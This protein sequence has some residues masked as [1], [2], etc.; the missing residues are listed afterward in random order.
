MRPLT[1][2]EAAWENLA[3]RYPVDEQAADT[4]PHP[5][6]LD[7]ETKSIVLE[8]NNF[9]RVWKDS[10]SLANRRRYVQARNAATIATRRAWNRYWNDW[11][12]QVEEDLDQSRLT[13]AFRALR[14]LY[15]SSPPR[16]PVDQ[17][18]VEDC[19][20]HFLSLLQDS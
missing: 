10:P 3:A 17:Q 19:A 20:R 12:A 14:R 5:E 9:W 1:E 11:A 7:A 13:Q 15:K 6:W 8:K 2:V 16:R 18:D 4:R